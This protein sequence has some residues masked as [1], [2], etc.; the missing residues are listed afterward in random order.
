MRNFLFLLFSFI[1]YYTPVR[2]M[3]QNTETIVF[4]QVCDY[5][6]TNMANLY[7]TKTKRTTNRG[8]GKINVGY[9]S[10]LPDSLKFAVE[11][12]LD[13]WQRYLNDEDSLSI[14]ILY[15]PFSGADIHTEIMYEA[16]PGNG[17]YYPNTLYRR[18]WGN[19]NNQQEIYENRITINSNTNWCI[20]NS[21]SNDS[22]KLSIA[23][24]QNIARCLGYGAS[25]KGTESRVQFY[26]NGK[27]AFDNII[28]AE[29]GTRLSDINNRDYKKLKQFVT[30]TYGNVYA[31][32]TDPK[33][34][35]YMSSTYNENLT[36]KYSA[37]ST[38]IM[39]HD[40]S[41][42]SATELAI[43]DVTKYLLN[44]IG[45]TIN[46]PAA[47][48][49]KCDE[50]DSTGIASAYS[51]H[52]FY[53]TN[54]ASVS[55]K[56]WKLELPDL[57]GDYVTVLTSSSDVF[58][59]MNLGETDN[60]KHTIDGDILGRIECSGIMSGNIVKATYAVT[61]ELKPKIISVNV[62]NIT[63]NENNPTY[64]DAIVEIRYEGSNYISGIVEEEYF[65]DLS[66]YNSSASYLTRL[67]L[68]MI[69]SWGDAWLDLTVN[70]QYGSDTYTLT[71]PAPSFGTTG[72]STN[73]KR[74][75]SIVAVS[76]N[77]N[78]TDNSIIIPKGKTLIFKASD[79]K[80][81]QWNLSFKT[82]W[83]GQYDDPII[84]LGTACSICV[85]S[86]SLKISWRDLKP[87][88]I[89]GRHY[90]ES[91]L[92]ATNGNTKEN[93][94]INI[95]FDVFPAKPEIFCTKF[96]Y[97]SFDYKELCFNGVSAD[98]MIKSKD[99]KTFWLEEYDYWSLLSGTQTLPWSVPTT[100]ESINDSIYKLSS[101]DWWDNVVIFVAGANSYGL[102][103]RADTIF[104]NDYITDETVRKV[105]QLDATGIE[106]AE[107]SQFG[108][109]P[110]RPYHDGIEIIN[111]NIQ[112]ISISNINGMHSQSI[113]KPNKGEIISMAKGIYVLKILLTD[114]NIITKKIKV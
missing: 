81:C 94:T 71:L 111:D 21:V 16:Y 8:F 28:I 22:K 99:C 62:L 52:N 42:N 51:T 112:Y 107:I 29:D 54:S 70:N 6:Q 90:I 113:Q 74:P 47:F 33:Y 77:T 65:S 17:L 103:T 35:L 83:S 18:L 55:N 80:I 109:S 101:T 67:S 76:A 40:A 41:L 13:A 26:T 1:S 63:E 64:Y 97:T 31:L 30:G 44:G 79:E 20:G 3:A 100:T 105:L 98:F 7:E 102:S 88:L 50:I 12:A 75:V 11:M 72:Y 23:I 46:F 66:Y 48:E 10:N 32:K 4:D 19:T 60:Y 110:I 38:S 91:Y 92:T 61:F 37:E 15:A 73:S 43:D 57:N 49:I 59:I 56:Q 108:K 96:D 58:S 34:K 95:L 85:N 87:V 69:D 14:S 53:V 93:D 104:T 5:S 25:L 82:K 2:L 39:Y 84:N 24:F 27:T 78:T 114:N 86:D 68:S 45:W 9:D 36:F 106:N 89:N